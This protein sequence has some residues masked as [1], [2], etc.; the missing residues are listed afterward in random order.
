MQLAV[1][2]D[3]N[4]VMVSWMPLY[5]DMG[6]VGGLLLAIHTGMPTY[7]MPTTAFLPPPESWLK[8]ISEYR[9][10]ISPGTNYA[11][12]NLCAR[13]LRPEKLAALDLSC[14]KRAVNGAGRIDSEPLPHF[15]A[16]SRPTGCRGMPPTPSLEWPRRRSNSFPEAARGM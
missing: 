11:R 5:H 8:A 12:Y 13:K 2:L 14:W 6:L 10:S 3:A 4:D 1:E 16:N 7:L 9:A 15:S